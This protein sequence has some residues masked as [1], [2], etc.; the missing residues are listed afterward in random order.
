[1]IEKRYNGNL[2]L[3]PADHF[4]AAVVTTNGIVKKDRRL[5]MGAGIAKYCRDNYEGIDKYLGTIVTSYGN[6]VYAAGTHYD[7]NRHTAIQNVTVISF[8]TKHH[9]KDP[10]NIGLIRRSCQ[11][12]KQ[13]ADNLGLQK[14]Y[15]PAPG[16]GL[17]GLD[18]KTEVR[19]VLQEELKDDRF[20]LCLPDKIADHI[21]LA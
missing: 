2:F 3:L 15:L 5:V 10:S 17:G 18:Y 14:I 21:G 16:C 19:P 13:I 20:I 8:P 7:K 12:L 6:H 4:E 11:E 9:F 1:M